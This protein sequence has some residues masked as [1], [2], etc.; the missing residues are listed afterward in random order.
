MYP[1]YLDDLWMFDPASIE[2]NW[3]SGTNIP[4][5]PGNY[6][7]INVP[8]A[9]NIPPSRWG[10]VAWCG[11]NNKFYMLGGSKNNTAPDF[12]DLWMFEP[13]SNCIANCTFQP[14]AWFSCS[15][16]LCPGTCTDFL[17]LSIN[18]SSYQWFF[19]GATPD[20]ST[21]TNPINICYNVQGNYDVTLIASD[22]NGS[23]T[24]TLQNYITVFPQPPAQSITQSGDT[25]FAIAGS[26]SYQWYFNGNSI[27]GATDYFYV[28]TASG[29][30]N[31]V[32]T[33][34]NGCEVEAVINDVLASAQAAV[35]SGSKQSIQYIL[36]RYLNVCIRG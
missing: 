33:D 28:A 22:V 30:Y 19:P 15:N 6:G 2:W 1:N 18:S 9:T 31:V 36:I 24:L 12:S 11:D 26:S 29:D 23:D 17:N 10:A 34:G 32:A 13:D 35:G 14:L 4:N 16:T 8:S 20:T 3:L 25:L 27:S 21:A 7:I 5:Q